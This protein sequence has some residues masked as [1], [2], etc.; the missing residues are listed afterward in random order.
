MLHCIQLPGLHCTLFS[1]DGSDWS[2]GL[3]PLGETATESI[4]NPLSSAFCFLVISSLFPD[5][6]L[7]IFQ[8]PFEPVRCPSFLSCLLIVLFLV[9][10][11]P[12]PLLLLLQPFL[13][14]CSDPILVVFILLGLLLLLLELLPVVPLLLLGLLFMSCLF[15][16]TSF[17]SLTEE[18]HQV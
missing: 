16:V 5:V 3:L 11:P 8:S 12:V 17:G 7:F 6:L 2:F 14:L 18:S 13:F 10:P 1:T 4:R 15:R 9:L